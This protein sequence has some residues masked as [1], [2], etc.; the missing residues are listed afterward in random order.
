MIIIRHLIVDLA[1]SDHAGSFRIVAPPVRGASR[2]NQ[3]WG[4]GVWQRT[5]CPENDRLVDAQPPHDPP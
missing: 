2:D 3:I 1:C 4:E 5:L